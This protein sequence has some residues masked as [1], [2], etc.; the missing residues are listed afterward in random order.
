MSKFTNSTILPPPFTIIKREK[1][2]DLHKELQFPAS[3]AFV[4]NYKN[5]K[6]EKLNKLV[7]FC[8]AK[9]IPFKDEEERFY[10]LN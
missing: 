7:D 3:P 4:N 8:K 1:A 10:K 6:E 9:N 5:T 2:L